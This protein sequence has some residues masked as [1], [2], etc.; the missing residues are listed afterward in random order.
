[1]KRTERCGKVREAKLKKARAKEHGD[2]RGGP[3]EREK[4][5]P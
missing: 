5:I 2:H 4:G 1:L 3:V